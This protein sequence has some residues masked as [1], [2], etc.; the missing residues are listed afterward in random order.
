MQVT[1][2]PTS[3]SRLDSGAGDPP[4]TTSKKIAVV[5]H[6]PDKKGERVVVHS[7]W[8]NF[9]DAINQAFIIRGWVEEVELF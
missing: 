6:T 9:D 7:A 5:L 1:D 3:V 4:V 8:Q 2:L